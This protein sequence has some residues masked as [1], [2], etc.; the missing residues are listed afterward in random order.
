ML[1]CEHTDKVMTEEGK[2]GAMV[3]E[4]WC[5]GEAVTW[6]LEELSIPCFSCVLSCCLCCSPLSRVDILV[7]LLLPF[8]TVKQLHC[9]ALLL[10]VVSFETI[11]Y[12][13]N[14]G[15]SARGHCA[16][17]SSNWPP[18][19]SLFTAAL[20]PQTLALHGR[21]CHPPWFPPK[22]PFLWIFSSLKGIRGSYF[23]RHGG[24]RRDLNNSM[25]GRLRG[26]VHCAIPPSP[27]DMKEPSPGYFLR[28][29]LHVSTSVVLQ[30]S[31]QFLFVLHTLRW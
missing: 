31:L 26:L 18:T 13:C 9:S 30:V 12:S 22:P 10:A 20:L 14:G 5:S 19:P 25:T 2:S 21:P 11:E 24:S 4:E 8:P 15:V 3:G 27:E 23:W 17:F 7:S 28:E 16:T 1:S 29:Q 6:N